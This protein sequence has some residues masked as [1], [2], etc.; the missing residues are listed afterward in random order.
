MK[1]N[2]IFNALTG[3]V[4][5]AVTI[6]ACEKSSLPN[7]NGNTSQQDTTITDTIDQQIIGVSEDWECILCDQIGDTLIIITLSFYHSEN[8]FFSKVSHYTS[9]RPQILFG[10]SSWVNYVISN[11]TMYYIQD[12]YNWKLPAWALRYYS[13]DIM[14]MYYFGY[15]PTIPIMRHYIFKRKK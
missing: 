7:G 4:L 6:T 15:L 11:D 1:T 2:N 12:S 13:N 10:D 3:L 14:E 9:Y 8:K 5:L